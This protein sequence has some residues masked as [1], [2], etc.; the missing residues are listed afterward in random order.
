VDLDDL[1]EQVKTSREGVDLVWT[2]ESD[3]LVVPEAVPKLRKSLRVRQ[4][5]GA[6]R[7]ISDGIR[8]SL[9][10]GVVLLWTEYGAWK[11]S[12]GQIT[13]LYSQQLTGIAALLL[14]VFGILPLYEGW[15]TRRH[16]TRMAN[17]DMAEDLPDAQ[18]DVWMQRHKAPFTY[19]LVAC[20]LVC[21]A[22][23]VWVDWGTP[24]IGGMKLSIL[25]AGLL[26][27][28]GLQFL[29]QF[30]DAIDRW[31]IMTTPMLHGNVVH[32]LM[33]AAGLLYLGRRT[34]AL[35]RWP[36]LLIV[37]FISMWVGGFTSFY[38]YPDRPAVGASGGIMGLLGFLMV[39]ESWHAKLVPRLARRR[40]SAG[41]VLMG[42]IGALGMSFIDNAAHVGGLLA[43]VVYG[44]IV[45]PSSVS[46]HR[47]E[48]MT[49]DKVV[50]VIS[51]IGILASALTAIVKML[52]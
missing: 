19:F 17:R 22:V 46:M 38:W 47:P 32:L 43:G 27:H 48:T 39:F 12:G 28:E 37:F 5:R 44:A 20:L 33:N 30:P 31:R 41:L 49:K 36:H 10:F 29:S 52:G 4:R 21:G 34:E 26:K 3:W 14:F 18:F 24:L 2:P 40:L 45:F 23:Q 25:R 16:L 6:D 8:M 50:G 7:D 51:G 15:K 35:T 42:V 9:F 1:A 13:A 11:N